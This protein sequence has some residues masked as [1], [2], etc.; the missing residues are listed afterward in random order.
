MRFAI[1]L[2]L[3]LVFVPST[4]SAV[5]VLDTLP[6]AKGRYAIES[7]CKHLQEFEAKGESFNL[8]NSAWHLESGGFTDGWE[9]S[10][11]FHA[12]FLKDNR[13]TA[14]AVCISGAQSWPRLYLLEKEERGDETA[15]IIVWS[16][17][18]TNNPDNNLQGDVYSWCPKAK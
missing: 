9:S 4:I 14:H 12:V 13:A 15:D 11:T 1:K 10:C 2:G 18:D 5:E 3:A 8:E 16:G 6:F 7:D 17:E